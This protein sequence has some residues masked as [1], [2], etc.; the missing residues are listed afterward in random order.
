MLWILLEVGGGKAEE[1]RSPPHQLIF[2]PPVFSPFPLRMKMLPVSL[3]EH[4]DL[5]GRKW[6]KAGEGCIEKSFI[7]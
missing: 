7:T 6:W 1:D 2:Y 3:T 4:L 5:R